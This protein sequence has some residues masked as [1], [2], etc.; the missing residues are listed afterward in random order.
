MI[1]KYCIE[2]GVLVFEIF[3]SQ[4]SYG[5]TVL[6][7][8]LYPTEDEVGVE[9][10]IEPTNVR[11]RDLFKSMSEELGPDWMQETFALV[12]CGYPIS[13]K[14]YQSRQFRLTRNWCE[15]PSCNLLHTG[16]IPN[17][18]LKDVVAILKENRFQVDVKLRDIG[19]KIAEV[20]L[21]PISLESMRTHMLYIPCGHSISWKS[22]S[23]CDY[24]AR[25][26]SRCSVC[27]SNGAAVHNKALQKVI[28]TFGRHLLNEA[29]VSMEDFSCLALPI[30][31][32]VLE[33]PEYIIKLKDAGFSLKD[34]S[35]LSH[36]GQYAA[37][38]TPDNLIQLVKAGIPLNKLAMLDPMAQKTALE[39][40]NNWIQLEQ[41]NIDITDPAMLDLYT[42]DTALME[43]SP[44]DFVKARPSVQKVALICPS[45]FILVIHVDDASRRYLL[46][47]Y[48][49][50]GE[51]FNYT[52][53]LKGLMQLQREGTS[54]EELS[55]LSRAAQKSAIEKP[56][57]VAY[58]KKAGITL[59]A[60]SKFHSETQPS[61]I[62]NP[63]YCIEVMS[64]YHQRLS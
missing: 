10:E 55:K 29:E 49:S 9:T 61:M 56:D 41:A 13:K 14:A 64:H 22:Y 38:E 35:T 16:I 52:E 23:S 54:I 5:F 1:I 21:D 7:E 33:M 46:K 57:H 25:F 4:I 24:F 17:H 18:A 58:L 47:L 12:P 50:T 26:G 2:V 19:E 31:E 39:N 32:N 36:P 28:K 53:N 51:I 59:A 42:L 60:I 6:E 20:V 37:M 3:K 11:I 40:P 8:F 27:R 48:P 30:Q 63:E 15:E 44:D 34:L 62:T 45:I 43:L